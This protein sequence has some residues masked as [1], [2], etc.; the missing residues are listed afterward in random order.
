MRNVPLLCWPS[1]MGT[2]EKGWILRIVVSPGE[3]HILMIKGNRSFSRKKEGE[4][5][6]DEMLH[7]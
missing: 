2:Q 6:P 7:I 5:I 4:D 1:E 3:S